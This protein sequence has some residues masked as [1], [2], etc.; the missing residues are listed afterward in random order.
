M[1]PIFLLLDSIWP[2]CRP[3]E[4]FGLADDLREGSRLRQE[5]VSM[6][7]KASTEK[8]VRE[9]WRRMRRRF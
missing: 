3:S 4:C 7:K 1:R 5:K 8:A 9:L 2:E 6:K